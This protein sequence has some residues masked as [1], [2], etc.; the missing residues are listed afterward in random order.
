MTT[1]VK[2][3]SLFSWGYYGWGNST[4]QLLQAVDAVEASRGFKPPIFVDI[5]IRRSVRAPGFR[6]SEFQKLLGRDRYRWIRD[7]GNESIITHAER[8][9]I[10]NPKAASELLQLATEANE[11]R[12]RV[13]F[14]CGC[15]FPMFGRKRGCH[16]T[17]VADLVLKTAKEQHVA[18]EVVEWPGGTPR[19]LELAVTSKEFKALKAGAA[20]IPLNKAAKLGE[21]GGIPWGTVVSVK[22]GGETLHRLSGPA[23]YSRGNWW[24]PVMDWY[25]GQE[26]SLREIN[27]ESAAARK[28][29]GYEPRRS[30]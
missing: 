14:F 10:R 17:L 7:L 1:D 16:R 3:I 2:A 23:V 20:S 9:K 24:L 13:V 5:R 15:E 26:F 19:H 30:K 25:R 21:V 8:M 4:K 29:Y 22:S 18:I 12:R 11:R 6:E 27:R 28:D